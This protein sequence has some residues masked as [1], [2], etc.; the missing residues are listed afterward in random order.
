MTSRVR[1]T[2]CEPHQYEIHLLHLITPLSR[3][4]VPSFVRVARLCGARLTDRI[5]CR[6]RD[7]IAA[8]RDR[9]KPAPRRSFGPYPQYW[10]A[11]NLVRS[12]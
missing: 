9:N 1:A 2:T 10:G 12:F 3:L 6:A 11:R 4:F 8:P 7:L 5:D